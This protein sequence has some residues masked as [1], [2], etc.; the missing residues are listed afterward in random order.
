MLSPRVQRHG[1][2]SALLVILV[3]L[4]LVPSGSASADS[5]LDQ[6]K[7]QADEAKAELEEATEEYTEREENLEDAQDELISTLHDLQ[8]TELRLSEMRVPLAQL[9]S[10]LYQQPDGG[11]LGVMTSGNLDQDLQVESHVLK[12]ADD[13]EALLEEANDLRD[14]QADLAGKAQDLQAETQLERVELEDDLAALREQ[15]E[16]STREL[17]EEL[18]NRGLDPDAYMAGVECDPTAG[19]EASGYPNG[20]LPQG[21]LCE[22]HEGG[23]FLRADAAVDFLEMNQAYTEEFGTPICLTSSYRDL[24][25]QHRVYQEQPPG[26]AAV[27][28]TS[29]HGWG[30]AV[31]MCG[32]VQTEGTPQFAWL[33]ANSTQWGW[34]HPQWA[35]SSPYE[36]WHWEYDAPHG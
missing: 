35:Y 3:A 12:L 29:N 21:A 27:P 26:N 17:T 28:G 9:G 20:L 11:I 31:D 14:R 16:E 24:P 10:T 15:S 13:K 33:E 32:G 34:F 1:G 2:V 7:Q 23:H 6:L 5:D 4:F 18:E 30:L 25:N 19:Q 22:L 8:Q 36:P